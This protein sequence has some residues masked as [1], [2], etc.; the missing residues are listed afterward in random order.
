MGN[1]QPK[2]T[3]QNA[4]TV[5]NEVEVQ[6][7]TLENTDIILCLYIITFAVVIQFIYKVYKIYHKNLKK[8]YTESVLNLYH[9][10]NKRSYRLSV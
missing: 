6:P 7:A 3:V 4:G 5:I 9:K 1:S 8:R 2:A 10:N